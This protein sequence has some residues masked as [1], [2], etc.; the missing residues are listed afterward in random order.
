MVLNPTSYVICNNKPTLVKNINYDDIISTF[1]VKEINKYSGEAYLLATP[2][3]CLIR[4]EGMLYKDQYSYDDSFQKGIPTRDSY[5]LVERYKESKEISSKFNVKPYLVD[6]IYN[7]STVHDELSSTINVPRSFLIKALKT[8]VPEA[9]VYNNRLSSYIKDQGFDD[10][11]EFV[12][13]LITANSSRFPRSLAI[14]KSFIDLAYLCLNSNYYLEDLKVILKVGDFNEYTPYLNLLDIKY[15]I[16]KDK[17]I[18]CNSSVLYNMFRSE[19]N[20]FTFLLTLPQTLKIYFLG[21]LL[22]RP[23]IVASSSSLCTLSYFFNTQGILVDISC[24]VLE[25]KDKYI[26]IDEGFLIPIYSLT[27]TSV[28][29]LIEIKY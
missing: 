6:G 23:A 14:T 21:L 26:L 9:E 11:S 15:E 28:K 5:L 16:N 1:P 8:G 3:G 13:S 29:D 4:K 12:R 18:I 10:Q 22:N 17:H 24:G 19:F 2:Y 20:S 7:V 27:K 25:F